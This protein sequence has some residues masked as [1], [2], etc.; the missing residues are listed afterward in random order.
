MQQNVLLAVAY[1]VVVFGAMYFLWIAPQQ[2]QRKAQAAML[3]A[4]MPGDDVITAGGIYGKVV[5]LDDDVV[6]L[7]LSAGVVV[8]VAKGAVAARA[9]MERSADE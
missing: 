5:S 6:R 1:A 4:L 8:R 9:G 3:A 7:E 2:K